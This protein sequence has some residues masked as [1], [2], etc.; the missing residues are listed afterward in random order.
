MSEG[1]YHITFEPSPRRIAVEFGGER[2]ADSTAVMILR[3]TRLRPAYY[4]PRADVRMDLLETTSQHSHCPFKGNARYWSLSAGGRSVDDAVWSYESPYDDCPEIAGYVSFDWDTMDAWYADEQPLAGE[5][6][7]AAD[8]PNAHVGWLMHAADR[9]A[10]PDR[11]LASFAEHLL[12]TGMPL[13][14]LSITIRT[15]HPQVFSWGFN[16]WRDRDQIESFQTPYETLMKAEYQASPYVPIL[17]GAGG[18]RRSLVGDA[19]LDY[20]ILEELKAAGGTDYAAMPMRFSDG[21]INILTLVAN[22]PAGFS[23]AQLGELHEVLPLLSAM[24]EV[25]A[26]RRFSSVILDTY[27]GSQTGMRILDGKIRRGDGETIHAVIW[28]SDLRDSTRLTESLPRETYLA[29]LNE[30]FDCMAGAV[31]EHG[32]EVLKYIGDA[33]MAIFPV[34]DAGD[35]HPE[36]TRNALAAA[37]AAA[38]RIDALNIERTKRGDEAIGFGV[39]LHRGDFTYGNI[40]TPRRL[41]FTVIGGAA[42]EAARIEGLTKVLGER[43]VVSDAVAASVG[44]PLRSLGEH[45]LR[46]VG[47]PMELF[48]P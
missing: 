42:N 24:F 26:L 33:V 45:S 38:V 4:F 34:A 9:S 28:F 7:L 11:L 23:T 25:H 5:Q 12:A 29:L 16:W 32:G 14:R 41:D 1:S 40:G 2:I 27:L 47:R 44:E 6:A 36:G 10:A 31:L 21:Q 35:E 22:D 17:S 13:L 48:A 46:G 3:E 39:A 43:I 37:R 20:P 18:V 30:Y 15:L 19:A 8:A